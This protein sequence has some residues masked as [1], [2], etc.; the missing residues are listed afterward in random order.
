MEK[1]D[2]QKGTLIVNDIDTSVEV[3][4]SFVRVMYMTQ[5]LLPDSWDKV[6]NL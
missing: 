2:L 6:K 3:K 1:Y 5:W 4:E